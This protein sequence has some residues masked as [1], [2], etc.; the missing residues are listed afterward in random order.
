MTL[1][2]SGQSL[3]GRSFKAADL[4]GAN[5]TAT[6]IRSVDFSQANLTDATFYQSRGGLSKPRQLLQILLL[7]ICSGTIGVMSVV[8]GTFSSTFLIQENID[9]F[10]LVPGLL[11]L[12]CFASISLPLTIQ[13]FTPRAFQT[14]LVT[15][16]LSIVGI[17]IGTL[18]ATATGSAD[19]A[20]GLTGA[21]VLMI[22]DTVTLTIAGLTGGPWLI[23]L[24]LFCSSV[25][26]QF[27]FSHTQIYQVAVEGIT[28]Q[29][30]GP[31][32]PVGMVVII[33]TVLLSSTYVAFCV[34][35]R[36]EKFTLIQKAAT[37]FTAL[38]GT[39]FQGAN[40][41]LACFDGADLKCTSFSHAKLTGTSFYHSRQLHTSQLA[42]TILHEVKVRRLAMCRDGRGK[43]FKGLNLEGINL[44]QADLTAADFT[45]SNLCHAVLSQALLAEANLTNLQAIGTQFD[46]AQ[47]TGACLEA[48]NIDSTTVLT[49]VDCQFVYLQEGQQERRPSS[50]LFQPGEFTKLFQEIIDTVD[51]IFQGGLD[52]QALHTMLAE[53]NAEQSREYSASPLGI[54]SIENKND[55]V[56][57]V[58]VDAPSEADKAQ[59]H[60]QLNQ[61]YQNALL[62]LEAKY[63]QQL[64]AKD[65]QIELYRQHQADLSAIA[66]S[67]ANRP[68]VL[69][70]AP[71]SVA[72]HSPSSKLVTLKLSPQSDSK[73]PIQVTLQIGYEGK[74]PFL[75]QIGTLPC[76]QSLL[77]QYQQWQTSYRQQVSL[78]AN[79]GNALETH[80][81]T[82]RISCPPAQITNV[83]IQN[84]Q[85]VIEQQT[86]QL[87][88]SF[89]HWL[90]ASEFRR[91]KESLLENLN[92]TDTVRIVLSTDD[93]KY[94]Q[95]PWQSWELL[96]RYPK[97]EITYSTS[98]HQY[99]RSPNEKSDQNVRTSNPRVFHQKHQAK[100]RDAKKYE[101]Q[102][103]CVLGDDSGIDINADCQLLK[104]LPNT[105]VTV[106][107]APTRQQL[108]DT[109]WEQGWD[110]LFFAGHS[111]TQ[112][113]EMQT[114]L[115]QIDPA[116]KNNLQQEKGYLR[117]NDQDSL[118]LTDISHALRQAKKAG[119]QL[120]IFNSCDG[121][122]LAQELAQICLPPVIVMREPIPDLVAHT[123][124]KG[125][126]ATFAGGQ[127]LPQSVRAAREKLQGLEDRFPCATWL[128]VL[129]QAAGTEP[130]TWQMINSSASID[131]LNTDL[132]NINL[133]GISAEY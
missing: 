116:Q 4:T 90:A 3:V 40:L 46:Q 19:S 6:D 79:L 82:H 127:P 89:N 68:V 85:Q 30:A 29:P 77:Q 25:I 41:T 81:G 102:I 15:G 17:T 132:S 76:A 121:L 31:L 94:W 133:S 131:P 105:Y 49:D 52:W 111:H 12:L 98:T 55:G 73:S 119:L 106:L 128:P 74:L 56:V 9:K 53:A 92:A 97:A 87:H 32:N 1:D 42:G 80:S 48:W 71:T 84:V 78:S 118:S 126:L 54:R 93:S 64:Q 125:L 101:T 124:L 69:P 37:T 117:L 104:E 5:F 28:D 67:L 35:A 44:T 63:Q 47:L 95:L 45:G 110:I 120:A 88:Y 72:L 8:A 61:H 103:L 113:S 112:S 22:A 130:L 62:S 34:L 21:L 83:N 10:T 27:A 33:A 2:F 38:G 11:C 7:L 50:G 26:A 70:A 75:E 86:Q 18:T 91:L 58:R 24:C 108:N 99:V 39:N 109:L 129:F 114:D 23:G 59:L 14:V 13:G 36:D 60:H 66:Q 122:G 51:L 65:E 16:T 57:V 123:F 107:S 96:K 20:G 43:D 115:I 100:K